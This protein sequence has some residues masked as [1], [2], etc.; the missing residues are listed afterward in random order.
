M[1]AAFDLQPV[2]Q[3]M[4]LRVVESVVEGTLIFAFAALLIRIVP[5]P[6]AKT[7]FAIWFSALLAIAL[8]PVA[9]G[10]W[11]SHVSVQ[12]ADFVRPAVTV[13]DSWALYLFVIWAVLAGWF[14]LGVGR[15]LWRLRVL[16]RDCQRVDIGTLDPEL[17]A[18]LE[19]SSAQRSAAL[20]TS[21]HVKVPT[22]IGLMKPM[23]LVPAWVMDELTSDEL[24]HILIHEMAHLQRGDDWSN[25]VQQVI[26]A[27]FFFH[28]A[29][30]WIEK[31]ISLEREIAC[32]DAVV[33]KTK[34]PRAYAACLARLA[35]RT[36]V[37]RSL[38]LAQAV[39][40]RIRQTSVRV[41]RILDGNLPGSAASWKP[42]VSLVAVFAI[43]FS[44]GAA[45]FQRL[46]GFE[47]PA[48][49]Q[50]ARIVNEPSEMTAPTNASW[51][52]NANLITRQ[53]VRPTQTKFEAGQANSNAPI[54]D[55]VRK[56][57]QIRATSHTSLMHLASS[58]RARVPVQE[59]VLVVI[60]GAE[61]DPNAVTGIEM[62]H[63]TVLRYVVKPASTT[64][65]GKQI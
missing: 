14:L 24:K 5:K 34:D 42:A 55:Q 58:K 31:E 26:K 65:P 47:G 9:T 59:T 39:L 1:I 54:S 23:I 43:V 38:A 40:G 32:D 19:S 3:Y 52:R 30:W 46:I 41:A 35:E 50:V 13:P 56:S 49:Q 36:F 53:A 20:C 33:A 45:K 51:V 15:A 16:K 57:P 48:A 17:R 6:S 37:Q 25:L 63:V 44:V 12:R 64:T 29:V 7:R 21:R 60:H 2:A 8:A 4:A 11:S 18:L 28:P 22:A 10:V 62:W 27:L 61:Q